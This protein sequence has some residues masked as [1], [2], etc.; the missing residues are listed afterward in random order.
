MHILIVNR[1]TIPVFTYGGTERV[2]WDLGRALVRAGHRVSYLVPPNSRCHFADVL[3]L[4][5]DLPWEQQIPEH[6]D[7]VHF[8][9]HPGR[10]LDRPYLMTEHGNSPSGVALPR[11]TVFVSANHAQRHASAT[12]VHNGLDW[13]NY[14]AVDWRRRRDHFHFLAK[15]TWKVKN[16]Q[17]A[18]DVTHDADVPLAVLGGH[19]LNIKRGFRFTWQRHVSFHGM[20]GGVQKFDLLNASRGLIFPVLWHEPFGLAIIESMY[21]GA[22]VFATPYGA[23]PEIVTPECGVLS[24]S[25]VTLAAAITDRQF[26]PHACHARALLFNADV[27]AR[28]YL[29]IYKEICA[30]TILHSEA[31][32]LEGT[33]KDLPW[34][35]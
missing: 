31:P 18:I 23:I 32:V 30:G 1:A 24:A 34:A 19:R 4:R 14:G 3:P 7:I 12:Y 20:V 33:F 35:K 9:F 16:V 8:Q 11:N 6:I 5:D 28:D 2:I 17:G 21:F 27:M 22:P 25:R 29:R 15:A 10:E 26:D 13:A